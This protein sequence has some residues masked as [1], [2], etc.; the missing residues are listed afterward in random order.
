[1][2]HYSQTV[3]FVICCGVSKQVMCLRTIL[4]LV[5]SKSNQ[6]SELLD[7][8]IEQILELILVCSQETVEG[9]KR[10]LVLALSVRNV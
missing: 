7:W 5:V 9:V 3:T 8:I 6:W 10:Y 2:H 4:W 1:M